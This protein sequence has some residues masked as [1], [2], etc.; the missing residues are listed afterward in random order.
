VA[1]PNALD[2][3]R[4]RAARNQS[5]FR[6]ANERLESVNESFQIVLERVDFACE[7]VDM[8]CTEA[9]P[10]SI[11]EY[12]AIRSHP[13]RF[14]VVRGHEVD[15]LERIVDANGRFVVVE[16]LGGGDEVARDVDPRRES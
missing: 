6:A 11:S 3:R 2:A 16:K 1:T 10:L 13:N 8:S 15:E 7:C 9:I 14:F 4:R 12:E 5:L